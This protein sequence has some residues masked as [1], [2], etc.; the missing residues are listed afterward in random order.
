MKSAQ[1]VARDWNQYYR[2]P[3]NLDLTP[4]PLLVQTV[5]LVRPGKALDIACGAGRNALYLARLGWQVTAVDSSE[6]AI[7]ILKE[8]AKGLEVDARVA[9]LERGEFRIEESA[10]DLICD[11]YYL[12]RKLFAP[13]REGVRPG[14]IFA[15][16]VRL[17]G[18]FA[19]EAGELRREF[20][21]WKILFYSE[22]AETASIVAR[23]A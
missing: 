6:A 14:G 15:G 7:A 1:E 12:Q 9:D 21:G 10:Y 18:S 3:A 20:E 22:A 4:V 2:E 23:R 5:E 16:A 11:F 8:N 13:M 19:A 17:A